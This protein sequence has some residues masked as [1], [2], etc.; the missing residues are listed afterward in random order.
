MP[1]G[2]A[3]VFFSFSLLVVAADHR[4]ALV[5]GT[6]VGSTVYFGLETAREAQ[7]RTHELIAEAMADAQEERDRLPPGSPAR[8]KVD[9]V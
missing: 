8:K 5:C 9:K 2:S 6:T 7:L 3:I 4:V 1:V